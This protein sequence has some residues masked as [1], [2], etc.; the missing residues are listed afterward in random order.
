[1]N[2]TAPFQGSNF[3]PTATSLALSQSGPAFAVPSH[4][5]REEAYPLQSQADF[6]EI[7]KCVHL[8]C[9]QEL[10]LRKLNQLGPFTRGG[11]RERESCA[12]DRSDL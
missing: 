6:N 7:K 8:I 3:T 12:L 11:K 5:G 9:S 4:Q 10:T 2:N 1:M